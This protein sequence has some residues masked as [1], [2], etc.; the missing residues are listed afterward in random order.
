MGFETA[1]PARGPPH[2]SGANVPAFGPVDLFLLFLP[3][4]ERLRLITLTRRLLLGLWPNRRRVRVSRRIW[5]PAESQTRNQQDD[6]SRED[7]RALAGRAA[8]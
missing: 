7:E 8:W 3:A 4:G 2:F 5:L 1:I 6:D